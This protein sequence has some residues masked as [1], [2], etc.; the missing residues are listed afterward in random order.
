MTLPT[1]GLPRHILG[2]RCLRCGH[3]HRRARYTCPSCGGNL[4]LVYDYRWIRHRFTQRELRANRNPGIRRYEPL[5]PVRSSSLDRIR[6]EMPV[7]PLYR[8]EPGLYLKDDTRQPSGSFKDRATLVALARAL[9]EK[10]RRIATA[11][12]GNAGV[13]LACLAA[14]AG[15]PCTIFV[16]RTAPEPKRAQLAL[17]G[18]RLVLVDGTYDDAYDLCRRACEEFG[19]YNRSTGLNPFTREGKK[20]C[21]YEIWEQLD[22]VPEYVF[23]PTGDGNILSGIWKGFRDLKELGWT[24]RMPKLVAVQAA[25]SNAISRAWRNAGGLRKVPARTLADSI[26]VDLPRDGEAALAALKE[27]GGFAVEVTDEE[28]LAAMPV[29]AERAGLFAE[30]AGAAAYAGWRRAREEGKIRE[31]R[32]AVC[33]VTGNGLKDIASAL[34]AP[35]DPDRR[36]EL[37]AGAEPGDLLK[38][39]KARRT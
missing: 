5:L 34:K 18:A 8:L 32:M 31:G 26:C 15:V 3:E 22:R 25:G 35:L 9:E 29:L 7:S 12:T 21:A 33:L 1:D 30:P 20:T 17:Y 13:S 19:W 14:A 28:I 2:F 24:D 36:M 6:H 39:E 23:V 16:P 4:D 11:S 38:M 10:A 27:T 37:P